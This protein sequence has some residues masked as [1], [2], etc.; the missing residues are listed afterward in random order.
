M[1]K[2]P[3]FAG[4]HT[5][6]VTPF[7]NGKIDEPSLIKLLETQIDA[8]INGLVPCGTTSESPT[9]T[10]QESS[11]ITELTV[12]TNAQKGKKAFVIAGTGSNSTHIAVEKTKMAEDQGVDAALVVLPYY[13][14][15]SPEGL[16]C[17]FRKIA[18]A[19][20][21]P[22]ILYSH[23][24]RCGIELSVT[25]ATR[26][27]SDCPNIVAIKDVGG[28][29]ERVAELK[30]LLPDTCEILSGDDDLTLPFMQ[31]GASGVI[32]VASNFIPSE[33]L[34][35]V[36]LFQSGD[37]EGAEK[38]HKHLSPLFTDLCIETNP[39]PVKEALAKRKL[40][41]SNEVRLPL[42]NLTQEHQTQLFKTL[43]LLHL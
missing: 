33:M 9:L 24:G 30:R 15:P 32:S 38:L 5:A 18:E 4:V 35:L 6:L 10:S 28:K 40:I 37:L 11:R 7:L 27:A 13:N 20:K 42:V 17:H 16:Y 23:P 21:I 19:V 2:Y 34:K 36:S 22:I 29:V 41:T 14:K 31:A 12:A 39:V 43:D 26:L 1:K 25:I 8:G 3:S